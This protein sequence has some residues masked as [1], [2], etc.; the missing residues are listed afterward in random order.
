[1]GTSIFK[2]VRDSFHF[3]RPQSC[4]QRLGSL[5][6]TKRIGLPARVL[7]FDAHPEVI[8]FV[9]SYRH[10]TTLRPR[11]ENP[12]GDTTIN[13]LCQGLEGSLMSLLDRGMI[14]GSTSYRKGMRICAPVFQH[15]CLLYVFLSICEHP[16][17]MAEES[18]RPCRR[19]VLRSAN[20]ICSAVWMDVS[21]DAC[22]PFSTYP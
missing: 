11:L 14:R 20:C 2:H 3:H 9:H 8:L 21:V 22:Y 17:I 12:S 19:T 18:R 16:S 4:Y 13:P 1:M 5:I 6:F 7:G 15:T 10:P